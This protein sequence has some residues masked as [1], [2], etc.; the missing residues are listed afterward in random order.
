MK[1]LFL[2]GIGASDRDFPE[3]RRLFDE[4]T[5]LR[6]KGCETL[7]DHLE[8]IDLHV[9]AW[10]K[11]EQEYILIGHSLGA[12]LV[13]R[14]I[15]HRE[16]H[17][18]RGYTLIGGG[19]RFYPLKSW[20]FIFSL[21]RWA[22]ALI[23]I[24]IAMG[25]PFLFLL[26]G[27]NG[28]YQRV[29]VIDL[30]K[31]EGIVSI[32]TIYNQTLVPLLADPVPDQ[33]SVP[34]A[35]VRLPNDLLFPQKAMDETR[36][37]VPEITEI[38][39]DREIIHFSHHL[40]ILVVAHIHQWLNQEG[41]IDEQEIPFDMRYALQNPH[42]V[43][44]E[45]EGFEIPRSP[46]I[47]IIFVILLQQFIQHYPDTWLAHTTI[48]S[49]AWI[50][51]VL[52]LEHLQVNFIIILS[53]VLLGILLGY[54]WLINPKLPAEKQSK[55]EQYP[56][57]SIIVPMRNEERNIEN[58]LRSLFELDYPDYEII[59]S[60]GQSEDNSVSIANNTIE[61]ANQMN[62]DTLILQEEELPAGWVGKSWGCWNAVQHA[63]GS[64][65]LFTDAD[66]IH[67]RDSLRKVMKTYLH[68]NLSGLSIIGKFETRSFWERTILPFFKS[69][70]FIIFGGRLNRYTGRTLAIGQY[71]L[72]DR[73]TYFDFDGHRAIAG[74]IAEDIHLADKIAKTGSFRAYNGNE[75]YQVRMY[76]SL[77]EIVAGFQ[78]NAVES[79]GDSIFLVV[80]ASLGL[81]IWRIL[82]LILFPIILSFHL[83]A[84]L[85]F[86]FLIYLLF[87]LGVFIIDTRLNQSPWYYFTLFPIGV[88]VIIG[89][90][91]SATTQKY[92][93]N[94]REWKGR[95]YLV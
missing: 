62:I 25:A 71:I 70:L 59:I 94:T 39:I 32:Q 91:L 50:T 24:F 95:N 20:N 35:V 77:A 74:K 75:I 8:R 47:G 40:D 36:N 56:T 38:E 63:I 49:V 48:N 61:D 28:M 76:R 37:L 82:P 68:Q 14:Y 65:I 46:V 73:Q 6:Y 52:Q 34:A 10:E 5:I 44:V 9:S 64:V 45:I 60:D 21:P 12:N 58:C 55:L 86:V 15:T 7:T 30:F 18:L 80:L 33:S 53:I 54:S 16:L 29:N 57:V 84:N 51:S 23:L 72:V 85:N 78:R 93:N 31:R 42:S 43:E 92:R 26:Y 22:I 90:L 3:Y 27:W 87:T 89:I 41:I 17:Y 13:Y 69:L 1:A 88:L 19:P 83:S 11:A 81:F 67:S 4:V 2:P 79:V 66:T